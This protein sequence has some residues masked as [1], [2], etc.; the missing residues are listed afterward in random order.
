MYVEPTLIT[1]PSGNAGGFR[2]VL[3]VA[4]RDLDFPL[5]I[6]EGEAIWAVEAWQVVQLDETKI[7][8]LRKRAFREPFQQQPAAYQNHGLL[9]HQSPNPA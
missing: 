7:A 9:S 6:T 3:R 8:R 1:N 5:R 2:R 4:P